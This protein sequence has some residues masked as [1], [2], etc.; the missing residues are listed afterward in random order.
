M[1]WL[2][3]ALTGRVIVGGEGCKESGFLLFQLNVFSFVAT[4]NRCIVRAMG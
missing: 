3:W 4:D 1:V 2:R